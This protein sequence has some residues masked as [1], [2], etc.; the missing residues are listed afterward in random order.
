MRVQDE[1]V[2]ESAAADRAY[3]ARHDAALE[4]LMSAQG[5]RGF[6][7]FPAPVAFIFDVARA[8]LPRSPGCLVCLIE[9]LLVPGQLVVVMR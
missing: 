6:I 7:R 1:S 8:L 9:S 4:P 3:F 2:F 5:G